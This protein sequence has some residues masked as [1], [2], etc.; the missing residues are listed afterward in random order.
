MGDSTGI[1]NKRIFWKITDDFED[2]FF[3]ISVWKLASFMV[4]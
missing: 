4:A 2:G 3:N 1:L